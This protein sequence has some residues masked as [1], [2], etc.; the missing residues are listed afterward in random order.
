MSLKGKNEI[1]EVL[2]LERRKRFI[3]GRGEWLWMEVKRELEG[4]LKKRLS[5]QISLEV[6]PN[7]ALGDLSLPC[8]KLGTP[9]EQIKKEVKFPEFVERVEVKGP[10]LN[11]FLKKGIIIKKIIG[12]V[13]R[14]KE[15]Y[16][17]N[18]FGKGKTAL[19]EHTSINP[20]ASPHVG[21]VRN[22]LIG[23]ALTRILRFEGYKVETHYFVNDVGKQIAMLVL[24]ARGKRPSFGQL[25]DLYVSF[26]KRMEEN[27]EREKEVLEVVNR[28]ERGDKK[29]RAEFKRVVDICV[30][31][32]KGILND[33][34]IKFDRF[35]YESKY[36]F[37]RK[38][39]E[40]V[41]ASLEKTGKLLKD[42]EARLCVNLEGLN[43]PMEHPYLPLTRADGTSLYLLRD[44]AYSLEK[45]RKARGRNL[46]VLGEDQKLYFLQLKAILSLLKVAAPEVVHYSFVLLKSGKMSTRKGHVVLLEDFMKEA[47]E[48]AVDE[49]VKRH[50][51]DA[52]VK[53]TAKRIADGAV[54]FSM[55]KV[56]AEKNII[57]DLESA[58]SFEGES[59][60]YIQYA[61]ARANSILRKAPKKSKS[62]KYDILI[63]SAEWKVVKKIADFEKV[64]ADAY[65]HL[66]PHLVAM[67][68][69]E[70][71]QVFNEFY[72]ECP[73]LSGDKKL[74]AA[75]LALVGAFMQVV[76]TA[77]GLLGIEAPQKM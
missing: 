60:P 67:Y 11:F 48:K 44:L 55:L 59:G 43:L 34:G 73:V 66:Q 4:F 38:A 75:R 62:P 16:G 5:C 29:I 32:Q 65:N 31:G 35:E 42:E 24:A 68:V 77:L 72:H 51:Q 54:K 15:K 22:A 71:A 47:R 56:S 2:A 46:V 52:D 50:G 53:K 33:L 8:F 19:I 39:L 64:V 17:S 23:D 30:R 57:F 3:K 36:V 21:R 45:A 9:P 40:N 1:K 63:H 10:Y 18:L 20:N 6:P 49:V 25:L 28:V 13:E 27:P 61:Y 70:F 12:E 76:K 37:E 7:E 69:L 26:N 74:T 58:L 41:L 14:K